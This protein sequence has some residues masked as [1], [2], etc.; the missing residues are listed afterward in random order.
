MKTTNI[1]IVNEFMMEADD[2]H[3]FIATKKMLEHTLGLI[4]SYKEIEPNFM[5]N[6]KAYCANF[7]FQGIRYPAQYSHDIE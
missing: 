1:A 2:Y 3:E 5:I 7:K 4:Y 6:N